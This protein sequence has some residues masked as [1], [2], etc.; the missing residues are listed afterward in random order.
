MTEKAARWCVFLPCSTTEV[1][2]VPQNCVAE[3]VTLQ[4]VSD[5]PPEQITWREQEVPVLDLGDSGDTPW[6]TAVAGKGLV[7]VILGLKGLGND[8]WAVA[9]RGEGLAVKDISAERVQDL[10]D[11]TLDR[12]TSAFELQ[13]VVYQVPDLRELQKRV[14]MYGASA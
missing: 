6:R 9:L 13:D 3:I 7:A 8:Y 11:R 2:A 10:P 14:G 12:S 4:D 1:W 5:I